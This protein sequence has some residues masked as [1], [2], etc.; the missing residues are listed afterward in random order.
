MRVRL[1]WLS[2]AC[3]LLTAIVRAQVT[4]PLDQLFADYYEDAL[5]WAPERATS[6]GRADYNHLW[7]DWSKTGRESRQAARRQYLARLQPLETSALP[8]DQKLNAALLRYQIQQALDTDDIDTFIYSLY[9]GAG[10]SVHSQAFTTIQAM[11]ARSVKDY[12]QIL[13][14]LESL[15]EYAT[16]RIDAL[17]EGMSR[18][19]VQAAVVVDIIAEQV[20]A[21]SEQSAE[22]SPL[23]GAFRAFPA[24]IPADQ[25]AQLRSRA[26]RAYRE[27]FLPSWRN[28]HVFL[29]GD[30]RKA[31]R[32]D[33]SLSSLPRGGDMYR[34]LVRRETTTSM[35]PD[36]IFAL[37]EREV[38]RIEGEMQGILKEVGFTG[39]LSAFAAKLD[40]DPTMHFRDREDMLVFERNI[41]KQAEPGLP[42]LFK[43]LPRAPFGIRPTRPE[44][45]AVTA[46]Y[47]D[48][49]AVDGTRAGF[50][51]LNTYRA[52]T[53]VK[54]DKVSLIL[55][56]GV[57]GHHLQ[58]SLQRELTDTPDFRKSF[59]A[60][61][62]S[63]GW[64]LYA[65]SLGEELG[66]YRDPIILFGRLTSE[67][68]RAVRL[69]VDTGLHARGWSRQRATDYFKE[70]APTSSLAEIDRYVAQPAQA[71]AYKV[72]ELK[73]TEL[74]RRA[75]RELGSTFDLR[76]FHDLVLSGGTL[77]LELLEVRVDEYIRRTKR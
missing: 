57:P 72:G 70:H 39:T 36:E 48:A 5:R 53:Q 59:R 34:A 40:A 10:S 69:V 14:R 13:T 51:N 24:S 71:L 9:Q 16:Q 6:L 26:E 55:H 8:N 74:R 41:A 47:Y 65:E 73:I 4:S 75:E 1:V 44:V 43:R 46:T 19:I 29:S 21:Q 76:E 7:S 61:A 31:A 33:M 25:Q 60:T 54:Y 62:F 11:P 20:R 22:A 2:A 12:E 56:E 27:A 49:P 67:R 38:A 28:L 58:Q 50:V 63:E 45:E 18:G 37:G 42:A 66:L 30:Y 68:F 32:P 3:L 64:G 15:P 17:R 52:E 35:T 77:P 23:L